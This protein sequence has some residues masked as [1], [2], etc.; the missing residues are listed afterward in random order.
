MPL[1]LTIR[2]FLCSFQLFSQEIIEDLAEKKLNVNIK[3]AKFEIIKPKDWKARVHNDYRTVEYESDTTIIHHMLMIEMFKDQLND[4]ENGGILIEVKTLEK[5]TYSLKAIVDRHILN[6]EQE[7]GPF[8]ITDIAIAHQKYPCI[9]K[10]YEAQ[11]RT[12]DFKL[13]NVFLDPGTDYK[14]FVLVSLLS[15]HG[16]RLA[17]PQDLAMIKTLVESIKADSKK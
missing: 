13:Y 17:T 3:Q 2:F 15:S 11:R 6:Y 10:L 5:G 16:G 7:F 8:A 9:S 14:Y 4:F 1:F 12:T